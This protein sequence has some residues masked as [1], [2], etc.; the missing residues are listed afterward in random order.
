[1]SLSRF[2]WISGFLTFRG[3]S[4]SQLPGGPG[5][6]LPRRF[7]SEQ[8]A[9]AAGKAPRVTRHRANSIPRNELYMS[10]SDELKVAPPP[11]PFSSHRMPE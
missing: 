4:G 11:S 5:P 7:K 10:S 1:M 9:F 2:H 6:M 8:Q 3:L